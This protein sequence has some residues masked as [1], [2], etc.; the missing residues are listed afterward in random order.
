[1]TKPIDWPAAYSKSV[2]MK[3][4]AVR[5]ADDINE[6]VKDDIESHF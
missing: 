2:R 6:Y 3:W 4:A 1:M 5:N